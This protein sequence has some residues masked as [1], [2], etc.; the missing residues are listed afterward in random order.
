MSKF[1]MESPHCK[2]AGVRRST[3]FQEDNENLCAILEFSTPK[4][5]F[6]EE[7]TTNFVRVKKTSREHSERFRRE[8]ELVGALLQQN[9]E[10]TVDVAHV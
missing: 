9:R 5:P 6:K 1:L 7:I 2:L 3:N 8:R 4:T 10:L